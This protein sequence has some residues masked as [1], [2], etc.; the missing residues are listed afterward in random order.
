SLL[1]AQHPNNLLFCKSLLLHKSVLNGPNSNQFWRKF[2]VAGQMLQNM[3]QL[4]LGSRLLTR[5]LRLHLI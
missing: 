2:S 4:L 5:P 1:L 3:L